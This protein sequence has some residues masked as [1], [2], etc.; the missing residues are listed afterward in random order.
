MAE[1]YSSSSIP[2]GIKDILTSLHEEHVNFQKYLSI[3]KDYLDVDPINNTNKLVRYITNNLNISEI[4]NNIGHYIAD[5]IVYIQDINKL[6]KENYSEDLDEEHM[7]R[8]RKEKGGNKKVHEKGEKK[9]D[10]EKDKN[11]DKKEDKKEEA[12]ENPAFMFSEYRINIKDENLKKYM[13][14]DYRKE[15]IKNCTKNVNYLK[16][17]YIISTNIFPKNGY[18]LF[19]NIF[20]KREINYQYKLL[21][22]EYFAN[23]ANKITLERAKYIAQI[24]PLVLEN[25]YNIDGEPYYNDNIN[26][27]DILICMC[28][29]VNVLCDESIKAQEDDKQDVA[30]YSIVA[31]IMRIISYHNTDLSLNR[32][33]EKLFKY[34]NYNNINYE[35]CIKIYFK[36]SKNL[37]KSK[38]EIVVRDC[39][40]SLTWRLSIINPNLHRILERVNI[41]IPNTKACA[42]ENSTLEISILCYLIL[43]ERI[44]KCCFPLVFSELYLFNLMI[45]NSYNLILCAPK[46]REKIRNNLVIKAY[47]FIC[48][49]SVLS[50]VIKK[51][52]NEY[53]SNIYKFKWRPYD[54]LKKLYETLYTYRDLKVYSKII[55]NCISNIMRNF[56]WDIFYSLY[57]KLIIECTT[58]HVR[59]IISSFVKDELY[60]QMLSVVKN[61]ELI[62]ENLQKRECTSTLLISN[63]DSYKSNAVMSMEQ[64]QDEED[65]E[66]KKKRKK[67]QKENGI[68]DT[69]N[70]DNKIEINK[71]GYQIRKIIY[72]LIGEESV[73]LYIDSITVVLNVI[74]MILLNKKFRPF[75]K[76]ILNFDQTSTCFLQN[77]IK[78][79]HD[80]IKIEKSV[81]S[82]EKRSYNSLTSKANNILEKNITMNNIMSDIDMNKL[83]IIVMLLSDI[84]KLIEKIKMNAKN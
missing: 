66:D 32:N 24:L 40:S 69:G 31:F 17:M 68:E 36:L 1:V 42:L 63:N 16:L 27:V 46:A 21:S 73:L 49:C 64:E 45:R 41:L 28:K 67:K 6:D 75:Y 43:I 7:E 33:V 26:N 5:I 55:Y 58:D 79:F 23:V 52:N 82:S 18:V 13:A 34:I 12:E 48:I 29:F 56:Q 3:L 2:N 80:Q 39:L 11:E 22:L 74:K 44:N 8:S 70:F 72:I 51:N 81:L 15:I 19:I 84:E 60:K 37:Y 77:K 38:K 57:N 59:S 14:K 10:K 47:H 54:F 30:L 83:E 25:F 4:Q 76:Y 20:H 71:L 53:Y 62:K 9:E 50:K 65:E 61:C 78:Y 35:E